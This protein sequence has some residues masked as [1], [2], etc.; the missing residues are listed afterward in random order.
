M[1]SQLK[2]RTKVL[3]AAVLIGAALV[4]SVGC[5]SRTNA[6]GA[7]PVQ[8]VEVAVVQQKDI[9]VE[10]EWIGTL[11]GMVNA[12]VKAQV[13][14][15]LLTQN[16][17]EGSFVRTGQLLFEID[18]RPLQ[19]AADQAEG[20]LAQAKAQLLQAQSGL[21]Q[22]RAQLL[23]SEANQHKAQLDEDRY[24]PL[25]KQQAIT[26]QDL[27][28]AMQ[29][30]ESQKAQV[31]AAKAQVETAQAQIEAAKAGVAAAAANL[32]TAKV[33]L[34]FTKLVSPIDGIVGAATVQVGNLVGP[35]TNA[36]TTV[37]TLDPIKANFTVSEQEYLSLTGRNSSMNRLDLELILSDGTVHPH[38]GR[39]SFA[40]R[41]VNSST[42]AIQLTGLFPNPDNRLRPGQ[43]GKVRASIG[44][45]AGALLV[46]QRAVNE[47]QGNYSVAVVD[48]NNTIRFAVVKVGDQ[49]GS[50][51]I[52]EDGLKPGE[53]VVA[54]GLF[55]IGPGMTVNPKGG[56]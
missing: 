17:A 4:G 55:K 2:K 16:Y 32:E 15:N 38:K 12:A 51:W 43:Y 13:T 19:A 5:S 11:D 54:D 36:V 22:A 24:I 29:S 41:E 28:N 23:S 53:R 10:R 26:Q 42:G 1:T 20:Q 7:P 25:A 56:K 8:E 9:P 34:G 3:G 45:R 30:N 21:L 18:P 40:D 37:S 49:V 27:D 46:P 35:S 39:F 47:M 6:A 31:A 14:G 44:T 50:D 52:V 48:P 33:N